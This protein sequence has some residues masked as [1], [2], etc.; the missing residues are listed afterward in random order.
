MIS[1]LRVITVCSITQLA[2]RIRTFG[3]SLTSDVNLLT[4]GCYWEFSGLNS[5]F[6][7]NFIPTS[8]KF[9]HNQHEIRCFG[10]FAA[11]ASDLMHLK[12]Y[13]VEDLRN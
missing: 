5:S 4:S 1:L 2:S 11:F 13:Q 3:L 10:S 6:Y 9:S 12:D 7:A 8:L